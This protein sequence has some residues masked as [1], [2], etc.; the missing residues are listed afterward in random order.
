MESRGTIQARID[1]LEN[2]DNWAVGAAELI[3]RTGT[4]SHCSDV[5]VVCS[6]HGALVRGRLHGTLFV[7]AR[8]PA[9]W[10]DML[11]ARFKVLAQLSAYVRQAPQD[12]RIAW[13]NALLRV[14]FLPTI[15]GESLVIRYPR[16]DSAS[17]ELECL[18][19]PA[20]VL[21]GMDHLLARQEG[22]I[23]L[24]GPTSSGKTTTLYAMMRRLHE[25]HGDRLNFLTIED[26][27]ERELGFASQVQVNEAQ[28]V[29]FE[30]TLRAALR[31]DP[32]VLLIGEIRDRETALI[33]AQAGMSGGIVLSTMHAGRATRIP[34]R[35]LSMGLPPYLVASA[36]S[37][38]V[39]QR[40]ARLACNDCS[41]KGCN[42]C[43]GTGVIGRVGL[44]E[45]IIVDEPMRDLILQGVTPG[46]LEAHAVRLQV[47]DLAEQARQLASLGRITRKEAE[48]VLAI[49]EREMD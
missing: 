33:A 49:E 39:A 25:C 2:N 46:K 30:K 21:S 43:G 5:H 13:E 8:I 34:V 3:L 41:G 37:G 10:Q 11:I 32:N 17:L 15:H 24:T 26:P 16:E 1:A 38:M 31:H 28:G 9:Q 27:V 20:E 48:I 12:G 6:P 29:D 36:L 42:Q 19:M 18:G 47:C 45:L 4:D 35:L 14:S 40:L 44:F 23:L 7:L 22:L